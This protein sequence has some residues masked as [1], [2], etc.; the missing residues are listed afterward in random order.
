[1]TT[2]IS[3]GKR[4]VL[5]VE[6]IASTCADEKIRYYV[7][8]RATANGKEA[9]KIHRFRVFTKDASKVCG[10]H[11]V[12]DA[13]SAEMLLDRNFWPRPLYARSWSF[14]RYGPTKTP[15]GLASSTVKAEDGEASS[16]ATNNLSS[17]Q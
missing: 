3:T 16:G 12:V 5:Y 10:A 8:K 1:M 17:S 13:A 2:S 9:P 15:F 4:A 14:E 7:F 6:N 11:L